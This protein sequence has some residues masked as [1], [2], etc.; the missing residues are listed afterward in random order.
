MGVG[1]KAHFNGWQMCGSV[2]DEHVTQV[3]GAVQT[4]LRTS[5]DPPVLPAE[6]CNLFQEESPGSGPLVEWGALK[7]HPG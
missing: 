3:H 1:A 4:A 5:P 6:R 7:P 2:M